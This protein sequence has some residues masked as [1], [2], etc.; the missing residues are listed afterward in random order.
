[1]TQSSLYISVLFGF[2]EFRH[3]RGIIEDL[4]KELPKYRAVVEAT[5]KCYWS[6]LEGAA[7]YDA[8]LGK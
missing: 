6:E 7:A 1:M 3:G 5:T 4:I 2:D 8:K